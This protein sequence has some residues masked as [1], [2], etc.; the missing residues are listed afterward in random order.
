M[1]NNMFVNEKL[2][3]LII[4][5]C[6]ENNK[7]IPSF[8]FI[9][10]DSKIKY[11]EEKYFNDKE[12]YLKTN[13]WPEVGASYR[14]SI[15]AYYYYLQITDRSINLNK[16]F[17]FDYDTTKWTRDK[18]KELMNKYGRNILFA[19][20]VYS[21][22]KTDLSF[23]DWYKETKEFVDSLESQFFVKNDKTIRK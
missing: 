22:V 11:T 6:Y 19:F 1:E 7:L 16:Y 21:S 8:C 23:D 18:L 13:V 14:D 15:W 9:D 2:F 20:G 10:K 5:D 4:K 3:D 12:E 17:D